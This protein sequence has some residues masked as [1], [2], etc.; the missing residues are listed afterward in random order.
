MIRVLDNE[1][2]N[3]IAAGEVV[4]RPASVVKELVENSIDAGADSIRIEVVDGGK[5]MIRISDNG[6]GM[7]DKDAQMCFLKHATSKI[8]TAQ[9]LFCIG[10]LGFRGEALAAISAVSVI[11]MTTKTA[12]ALAGKTYHVVAGD[13]V[14]AED[15]GSI[16]GTSI[17]VQ[18]LFYN[19]P[20]RLKFLKSEQTEQG[21]ITVLVNRLA[22][23][24]PEI[25][26]TYII[27]GRQQLFTSGSGQLRDVIFAVY[28]KEYADNLLPVEYED[29]SYKV[30]GFVGTPLFNKPNRNWQLFF[31]NNR[32]V[33]TKVFQYTL[34]N[35]FRNSMLTSRYPVCVLFMDMPIQ[36]V[37]VNV[38]PNKSEVKF[39][40]ERAVGAALHAAIEKALRTDSGVAQMNLPPKP[41]PVSVS[42]PSVA[43]DKD[44]SGWKISAPKHP[45]TRISDFFEEKPAPVSD[46]AI[47][48][49]PFV[50][51]EDTVEKIVAPAEDVADFEVIGEVFHSYIL[52]Q[53]GEDVLF[54]DKHALHE[55]ML[56]EKLKTEKIQMQTLLTPLV[57]D[58]GP[59]ENAALLRQTTALSES[60]FDVEDFGGSVIVRGIPQVLE[61]K[62]VEATLQ[63]YAQDCLSLKGTNNE[64]VDTF[65]H[66]IA[67]KA[68]VK[69]GIQT[70]R[71]ELTHLIKRYFQNEDSLK[72]CP[73]GRP[74][75]FSI[76]KKEIEK[77]FKRIV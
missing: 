22:M 65:L 71:F 9:D 54:I 70:S 29:D 36:A 48:E 15:A 45:L 16:T 21:N 32:I 14:S 44:F 49:L 53:K 6:C 38:H 66:T 73:H 3:L 7:S 75:T 19:T 11:D 74:I 42:P 30:R 25:S 33:R 26:F 18:D 52:V 5:K 72:Y 13:I 37:D 31:V 58:F 20:A 43:A 28:G 77:Q 10:T 40:D 27:N 68:A 64:I 55:R 51:K 56:F 35:S 57:F 12:D 46:I 62:D 2:S 50:V 17:C 8:K 69:S 24:H 23:S 41:E 47:P 34:E 60:G 1:I 61:N 4:E 76:S 59:E 63:A 67:C 39:A